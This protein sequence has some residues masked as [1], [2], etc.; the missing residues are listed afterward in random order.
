MKNIELK[1]EIENNLVIYYA[2]SIS[3]SDFVNN[4]ISK[5]V[6][7]NEEKEEEICDILAQSQRGWDSI[8]CDAEGATKEQDAE[9]DEYLDK[10]ASEILVICEK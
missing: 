7:L 1:S 2:N 10:T 4:H 5:F 6:S 9:M 8:E 3:S